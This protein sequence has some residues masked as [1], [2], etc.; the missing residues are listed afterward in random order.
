VAGGIA[1]NTLTGSPRISTDIDLFH[2]PGEALLWA[3]TNDIACIEASGRSIE[4][5]RRSEWFVEGRVWSDSDSVI[6]QWVLD[7]AY[8]FFPLQEHPDFGLTLHPFDLA[9]NKVLALVGRVVIRDWIDTITCSDRVQPLGYL[10]WAAS[11]KD[12]GLNPVFIL[13]EAAR[14]SRYSRLEYDKLEF[15]GHTPEPTELV[16]RW[17]NILEVAREIVDILPA[18]HV[19]ECVL[20]MEGNLLQAGPAELKRL[21][22]T[23]QVRWHAGTLRGAYPVVKPA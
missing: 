16:A 15:D 13:G 2:D 9:T 11:G 14:T 7:S 12:I 22:A 21:L 8:R 6:L 19:G 4:I 1:L 20:D 5:L 10:A 3:V 23:E 17:R 18:S